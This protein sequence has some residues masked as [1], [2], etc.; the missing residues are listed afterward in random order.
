MT[1]N[2]G[3]VPQNYMSSKYHTES[4]EPLPPPPPYPS[5]HAPRIAS[6][7]SSDYVA[8]PQ[9]SHVL[10]QVAS[11][12]HSVTSGIYSPAGTI[13]NTDQS[14]DKVTVCPTIMVQAETPCP[15]MINDPHGSIAP[16]NSH[17]PVSYRIITILFGTI[18]NYFLA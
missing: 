1:D 11:P 9:E 5:A 2:S 6:H 13:C 4:G 14:T 8:C 17:V 15:P 7:P 10:S 18:G 3:A 12:Q 16:V